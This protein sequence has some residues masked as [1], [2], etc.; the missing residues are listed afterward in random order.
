[1]EKKILYRVKNKREALEK[2]KELV[3]NDMKGHI[4]YWDGKKYDITPEEHFQNIIDWCRDKIMSKVWS[5]RK[6]SRLTFSTSYG[7][8]HNC[9]RDLKCYVAN[10]WM[11]LAMIYAGLE[12]AIITNEYTDIND[13]YCYS[14]E[15]IKISDILTN[16]INFIVRNPIAKKDIKIMISDFTEKIE[17]IGLEL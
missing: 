2:C 15:K 1:M 17:L 7:A 8:K 14:I 13:K 12:V 10:N 9:E 3:L 5:N 6:G 16:H 11:K 4:G